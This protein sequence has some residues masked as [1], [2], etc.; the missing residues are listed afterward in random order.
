MWLHRRLS[1]NKLFCAK[2]KVFGGMKEEVNDWARETDKCQ[3]AGES[4]WIYS[5][6]GCGLTSVSHTA[7]PVNTRLT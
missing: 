7:P 3:E 6:E 4:K 1:K 5:Q 2:G